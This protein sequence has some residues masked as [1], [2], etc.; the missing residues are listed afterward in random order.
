MDGVI[1]EMNKEK[2]KKE[3]FEVMDEVKK[4][5][6]QMVILWHN[7]SFEVDKWEKFQELYS[8]IIEEVKK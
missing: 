5:N 1:I 8:E 2:A 7:S 3:I 4:Y 6:G